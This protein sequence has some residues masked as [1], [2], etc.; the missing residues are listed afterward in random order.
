MYH[1]HALRS[2]DFPLRTLYTPSL[3]P[4]C[5][6]ICSESPCRSGTFGVYNDHER[7][8]PRVQ[9]TRC[10]AE[11]I[12]RSP[13]AVLRSYADKGREPN[14]R[15]YVRTYGNGF[16]SVPYTYY[17][18]NSVL[19]QFLVPRH[20]VCP[21]APTICTFQMAIVDTLMGAD[22]RLELFNERRSLGFDSLASLQLVLFMLLLLRS[23][24]EG[25]LLRNT[26]ACR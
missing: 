6:Q 2:S 5:Y 14:G 4:V 16:F 12:G 22:P 25:N 18:L 9:H 7:Y 23:G 20:S 26:L 17:L 24:C 1:A 3:F 19:R 10:V 11:Q 13:V 21:Q 15:G 8:S